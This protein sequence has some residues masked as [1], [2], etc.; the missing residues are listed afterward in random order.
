MTNV[1][2]RRGYVSISQAE[3]ITT[4]SRAFIEHL[5]EAEVLE[6]VRISGQTF[7]DKASLRKIFANTDK[8]QT[9][10][11]RKRPR[12]PD[13]KKHIR[14]REIKTVKLTGPDPPQSTNRIPARWRTNCRRSVK[15]AKP[16]P[17]SSGF[18]L[19]AVVVSSIVF[20]GVVAIAAEGLAGK[21]VSNRVIGN[22]LSGFDLSL[23][24]TGVFN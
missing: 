24:S 16:N 6:T 2:S 8:N 4:A 23:I 10:I 19:S 9:S 21:A 18:K 12:F 14:K 3:K 13:L 22:V 1:K 17:A 11:K 20:L 7:I 15:V 5:V